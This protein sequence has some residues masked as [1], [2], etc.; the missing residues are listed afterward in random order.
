[1]SRYHISL[2]HRCGMWGKPQAWCPRAKMY[3]WSSKIISGKFSEPSVDWGILGDRRLRGICF[4]TL[5]PEKFWNK[6][7][8]AT[9]DMWWLMNVQR[10]GLARVKTCLKHV[11]FH[12]AQNFPFQ[13][14]SRLLRCFY[15]HSIGLF[16]L[17][18]IPRATGQRNGWNMLKMWSL[19]A[20]PAILA[21]ASQLVCV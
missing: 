21:G 18:R 2:Y 11:Y 19:K 20:D 8:H 10:I 14:C 9:T 13:G 15:P 16:G 12:G 7:C 4:A 1:M 3:G 5:V 6:L 17:F